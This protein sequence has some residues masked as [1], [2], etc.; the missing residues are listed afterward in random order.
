MT[1]RDF[2]RLLTQTQMS[3]QTHTHTQ[4]HIYQVCVFDGNACL[5]VST[6]IIGGVWHR[7]MGRDGN[8]V[9]FPSIFHLQT[10][11]GQQLQTEHVGCHHSMV[12]WG[13]HSQPHKQFTHNINSMWCF[14][15]T[16]LPSEVPHYN[17]F[18]PKKVCVV[19]G[20]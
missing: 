3:T 12:Y 6:G 4:S 19:Q 16:F 13:I 9:S 17:F 10:P 14:Q 18:F 20:G 1:Y 15:E 5:C 8:T 11:K 7:S 2:M